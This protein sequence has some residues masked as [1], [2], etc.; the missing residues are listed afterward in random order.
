MSTI[1]KALMNFLPQA[2]LLYVIAFVA[3]GGALAYEVHHLKSEGAAA[4]VVAD[5]KLANEVKAHNTDLQNA[6]AKTDAAIEAQYESDTNTAPVGSP[7]VVCNRVAPA[8]GAVPAARAGAG[9]P[10][11]GSTGGVPAAADAGADSVDI[12]PPLDSAGHRADVQIKA[13][14]ADVQELLAEMAGANRK[15]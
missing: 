7:H 8:G 1:F 15:P 12:G 4:Q 11:Q 14:Q 2:D 9:S 6:A 13:L 10:S 5:T 3:L